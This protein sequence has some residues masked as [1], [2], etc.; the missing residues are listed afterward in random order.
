MKPARF[1]LFPLIATMLAVPQQA[2]AQYRDNL[3]TPWSNPISATMS[4]MIWTEI[5]KMTMYGPANRRSSGTSRRT[6]NTPSQPEVVPAYRL[7]PPVRFKS[8][9]TRL[10]LQEMVDAFGG[11]AQEKAEMK[12]LLAGIL[13]KY[14][15]AAAAKGYP[16][17]LALAIVSYI[18]LNSQVYNQRSEETILPFEQNIGLRDVFAESAVDNGIFKDVT[19]RQK[20]EMY[21]AFVMMGGVTF[22]FYEQAK[23]KNDVE[24]LKA[25]KVVAEKN[26]GYIGIKP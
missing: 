10:K 21:E 26:L 15:A 11:T 18:G 17:D 1:F 3:G 4:T 22:H 2:A 19:D 8:T 13:D 5:N 25:C 14:D 16:N 9:G 6:T 20:Q 24:E 23:K 7:Y 12:K